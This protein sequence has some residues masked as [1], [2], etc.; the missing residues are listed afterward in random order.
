MDM[1]RTKWRIEQLAAIVARAMEATSYEGQHSKRVRE[2]PDTRVIRY[3]TTLGILDRP[4]EMRGRTAYYGWRHVLQLVAIKRLQAEGLSLVQVQDRLAGLDERR[5][6]QLAA[7]PRDFL[8][9]AAKQT[10]PRGTLEPE[11]PSPARRRFWAEPP[12]P[13]AALKPVHPWAQQNSCSRALVLK[14]GQ[15]VSLVW[16]GLDLDALDERQSAVLAAALA[17]LRGTLWGAGLLGE[18]A[19]E[20]RKGDGQSQNEGK[21]DDT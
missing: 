11:A 20:A 14:V 21:E 4:L 19:T 18:D 7:V 15:G 17:T 2:V 13:S 9:A 5:L 3:Y 8:A 16:E 1:D 6:S 12:N 10:L